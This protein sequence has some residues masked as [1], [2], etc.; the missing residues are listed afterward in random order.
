ML[1]RSNDLGSDSWYE[2]EVSEFLPEGIK[3]KKCGGENF[4]K[5]NDIL[6]V[7]FESGSSF[8]ILEKLPVHIFPANMYLEGGDQYR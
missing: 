2:K 4:E 8:S 1:F 7:W 3:C 6:D 5:G